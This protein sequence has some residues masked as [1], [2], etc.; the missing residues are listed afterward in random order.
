[1]TRQSTTSSVV[2]ALN[3]LIIAIRMEKRQEEIEELRQHY[4]K[5]DPH[6]KGSILEAAISAANSYGLCEKVASGH[7]RALDGAPL[8][9][10]EI[11]FPDEF[12]DM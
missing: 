7:N 2:D 6:G 11:E 1:M 8:P 5:Y 4:H 3:T 10:V 12:L 9:R